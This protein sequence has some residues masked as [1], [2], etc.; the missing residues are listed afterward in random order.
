M[1]K[2]NGN[3]NV[4]MQ[5]NG[6]KKIQTTENGNGK[7]KNGNGIC[8]DDSSLPVKAQTIDELHSLQKKR[9][10]PTTP[11]KGFQL[12]PTFATLSEEERQIQQLQSIR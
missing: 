2:E 10:A 11:S 1:E 7:G 6:L 4:G 3:L 12:G 8:H 5:G 9:S